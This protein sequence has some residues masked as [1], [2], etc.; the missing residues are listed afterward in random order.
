MRFIIPI[1]ES[2][3]KLS[4]IHSTCFKSIQTSISRSEIICY[5]IV[6]RYLFLV[7]SKVYI[8]RNV[9]LQF[10]YHFYKL[11]PC[12]DSGYDSFCMKQIMKQKLL[13]QSTMTVSETIAKRNWEILKNILADVHNFP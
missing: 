7:K 13:W 2:A 12:Y 8:V 3:I 9:V 5:K 10:L 1:V 4:I 6:E 11:G